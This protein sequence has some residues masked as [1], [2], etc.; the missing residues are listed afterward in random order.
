MSTT[1]ELCCLGKN[2]K[3]SSLYVLKS[4]TVWEGYVGSKM[5]WI[6]DAEDRTVEGWLY[7]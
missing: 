1:A 6:G 4:D 5:A 3:G 2:D 7:S